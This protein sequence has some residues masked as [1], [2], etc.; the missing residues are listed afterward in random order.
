MKMLA[1]GL[2]T[3]LAG[4]TTSMGWPLSKVPGVKGDWAW[5]ALVIV[6]PDDPT[7]VPAPAGTAKTSEPSTQDSPAARTAKAFTDRPALMRR[8]LGVAGSNQT[9]MKP[10]KPGSGTTRIW[11]SS[12]F[13]HAPEPKSIESGR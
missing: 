4:T 8:L 9:R 5:A 3:E 10:V 6:L 1:P 11:P 13:S 12:V 2:N 7:P